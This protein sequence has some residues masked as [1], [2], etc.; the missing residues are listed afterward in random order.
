MV[1]LL[2]KTGVFE[3]LTPRIIAAATVDGD[4]VGFHMPDGSVLDIAPD[5]VYEHATE[6]RCTGS[7]GWK[8][9]HTRVI[10]NPAETEQDR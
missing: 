1:Y 9:E 4:T 8:P 3:A 6:G 5:A 10:H 7:C 2:G